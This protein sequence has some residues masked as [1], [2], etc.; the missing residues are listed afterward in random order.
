MAREPCGGSD[1]QWPALACSK[2]C[3]RRRS[4]TAF[5]PTWIRWIVCVYAQHPWSG[6]CQ[7]SMGGMASSF[8]PD[9]DGAGIDPG[10]QS[11]SPFLNA[12]T[13]TSFS[14]LLSS[15]SARL[16]PC[17]QSRKKEEAE[18][19]DV[20]LLMW[21]TYGNWAVQRLQCGKVKAKPGQKTEACLRVTLEKAMCATKRCMSLGCM[22]LLTRSLWSCHIALDMLC[23]D[24]HEAW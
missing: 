10:S 19:M 5:G 12:D 18:K 23:Q 9:S 8:L 24:M 20:M 4:G 14:L 21:G 1:P 7:G 6:M 11:I 2:V 17:T 16:L 22:G 15:R 3:G 13:R